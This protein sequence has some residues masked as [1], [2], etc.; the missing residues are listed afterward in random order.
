[1]YRADLLVGLAAQRSGGDRGEEGR[2]VPLHHDQNRS[3]NV[4]N[5]VTERAKAEEGATTEWVDGG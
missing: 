3:N 1:V 5:L 2:P 4:Y